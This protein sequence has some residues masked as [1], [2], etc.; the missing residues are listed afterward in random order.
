MR[1]RYGAPYRIGREL[2]MA[3]ALL[4][5]ALDEIT[6]HFLALF[7]QLKETNN[8]RNASNELN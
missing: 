3:P 6:G 5:G 1:T 8:L 7:V 2:D 4:A